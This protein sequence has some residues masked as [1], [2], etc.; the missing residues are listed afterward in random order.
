MTDLDKFLNML[1][2]P[3]ADTRYDACEEL[4]VATESSPEVVLALE[5]AAQDDNESV[6]ERAKSALSAEVHIQMARKMGR[7]VPIPEMKP[8]PEVEPEPE[9]PARK[10]TQMAI[11]SFVF[12]IIGILL[13]ALVVYPLIVQSTEDSY[14]EME[15]HGLWCVC[16][17]V[18]YFVSG[19][20]SLITGTVAFRQIKKDSENRIAKVMAVMGIILGILNCIISVSAYFISQSYPSPT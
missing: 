19:I 8:V 2:S 9:Q 20:L 18:P 4:R 11:F 6:A 7:Y 5:E 12:G 1:K 14:W 10:T 16:G 15:A 13:S 17:L 3:K